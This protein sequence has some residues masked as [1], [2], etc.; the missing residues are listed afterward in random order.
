MLVVEHPSPTQPSLD[1]RRLA[2]PVEGGLPVKPD[3]VGF[4][5]VVIQTDVGAT[6]RVTGDLDI[7]SAPRLREE[8]LGLINRG[9]RAVTVDLA[10]L[11]FIDSTGL[12]VL[13][14]AMRRLREQGGDLVLQSL[15]P[16]ALRVFEV[17]GLTKVF[18]IT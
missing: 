16:P 12:S 4:G 13:V 8:L 17:T 5:V 7:A 18:A 6:V 11:D 2:Q 1:D 3:L 9:I 15:Y 10:R 14:S